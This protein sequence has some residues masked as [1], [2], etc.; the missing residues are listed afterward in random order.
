MSNPTFVQGP[1]TFPAAEAVEKFTLVT[2]DE[3]GAVKK[4]AAD[5]AVFGAVTE[6]GDP[7]VTTLPTNV[8]VHYGD[9]AVKLKVSGGDAS[10]IKAGAA[11]YAADN[12]EVAASG[13]V[14]VGV[15]VRAGEGDRVLTVLNGLP[16]ATVA[17]GAAG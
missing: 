5:G 2:L 15:A 11:V 9:E 16:V 12:G 3:N 13:T 4:A 1:I 8:A 10:G 6:K 14:Q 17:A 7:N